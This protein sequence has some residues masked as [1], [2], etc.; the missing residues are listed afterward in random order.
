MGR[1]GKLRFITKH[2]NDIFLC[3]LLM[4]QGSQG[5][6]IGN[7]AIL[8][9]NIQNQKSKIILLNDQ[10]LTDSFDFIPINEKEYFFVCLQEDGQ[11]WSHKLNVQFKN[12]LKN[13]DQN[14]I[15]YLSPNDVSKYATEIN[16]Y[17]MIQKV[18][19]ENKDRYYTFKQHAKITD[20]FKVKFTNN[21][22]LIQIQ[23]KSQKI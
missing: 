12:T 11:I 6:K 16:R 20:H 8:T 15:A 17:K 23:E 13:C 1:I 10:G 19:F 9:I 7:F 4:K 5:K 3:C 2:Q 21:E 14:L 22:I 18:K